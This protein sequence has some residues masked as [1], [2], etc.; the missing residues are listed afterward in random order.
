MKN[1][2]IR[3]RLSKYQKDDFLFF[4]TPIFSINKRRGNEEN[5]LRSILNWKPQ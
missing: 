2:K 1:S 3:N 4:V 5:N